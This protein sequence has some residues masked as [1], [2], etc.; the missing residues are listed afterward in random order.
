MNGEPR[1]SRFGPDWIEVGKAAQELGHQ[2]FVH[3]T[4]SG[5]RWAF[6][7]SCGWNQPITDTHKPPTR[8]TQAEAL[9]TCVWHVKKMVL[10]QA[11]EPARN[12]VSVPRSVGGRL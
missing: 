9:R 5:R 6:G 8:A 10:A 1:P 2:T 11:G 3:P 4:K 7:C 12:G